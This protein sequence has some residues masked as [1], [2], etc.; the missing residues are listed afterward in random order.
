[1]LREAKKSSIITVA[2]E[3]LAKAPKLVHY[4]IHSPTHHV[5]ADGTEYDHQWV[6]E[7]LFHSENGD[8]HEVTS[9]ADRFEDALVKFMDSVSEQVE[10]YG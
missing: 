10:R 9:A 2:L 3:E 5:A 4:S 8:F 1:M 6:F 7:G